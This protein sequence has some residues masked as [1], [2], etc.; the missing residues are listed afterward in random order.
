[1][2]WLPWAI[3]AGLVV[4][5]QFIMP[6]KLS[7]PDDLALYMRGPR[8]INTPVVPPV[9]LDRL[10][11]IVTETGGVNTISRGIFESMKRRLT[12]RISELVAKQS[13]EEKVW[14]VKHS[15][16]TLDVKGKILDALLYSA[17][18]SLTTRWVFNVK[19]REYTLTIEQE[20][21]EPSVLEYRDLFD[22]PQFGAGYSWRDGVFLASKL[23]VWRLHFHFSAD[24]RT[25]I[26]GNWRG[27]DGH[28]TYWF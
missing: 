6:D 14:G 16:L 1:M 22:K 20:T 27:L 8:I 11:G 23:R 9:L 12:R 15:L 21:G 4:W 2:K 18:D 28:V 13:I 5:Y 25:D 24:Q 3:I 19:S 10:P 26:Y 17:A 7:L